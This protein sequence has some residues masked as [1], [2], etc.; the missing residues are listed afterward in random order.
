MK[1]AVSI[2]SAILFAALYTLGMISSSYS[3]KNFYFGFHDIFFIY[4]RYII[5]LLLMVILVYINRDNEKLFTVFVPIMM[6]TVGAAAYIE[7]FITRNFLYNYG[8]L[9]WFG[10]VYS[11]TNLGVL[12]GNLAFSGKWFDKFYRRFWLA[13]IPMYLLIIYVAFIRQP[14]SYELTTNFV[15]GNGTLKFFKAVFNDPMN[16]LYTS[17][18]CFGNV[19]IIMPLPFII[20]AIK[21]LPLPVMLII[22]LCLPLIF[23]GYQY[24]FKCGNVDVDDVVLNYAGYLAGYALCRLIENKKLTHFLNE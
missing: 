2:I 16:N 3:V 1:K 9:L 21:K 22:G 20:R 18:I 17:L 23:E 11:I 10:V 8:Y 12:L 5:I 13:F 24:V 4:S 19:F 6:I 15:F 14:E 7:Y